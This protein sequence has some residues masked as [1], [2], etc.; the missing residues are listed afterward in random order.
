MKKTFILFILMTSISFLVKA[1]FPVELQNIFQDILDEKISETGAIGISAAVVSENDQWTAA[2]GL[3]ATDSV[4]TTNSIMGMGSITKTITSATILQMMEDGLL[5]LSDPISLYLDTMTNIPSE[6]TISQLLNHTSGIYNYSEHP[7]NILNYYLE[8]LSELVTEEFILENYVDPPIFAPGTQ[9]LYSNSNYLLLALIIETISG[10]AYYLEARE[11]FGFDVNYP[12]FF[13]LPYEKDLTEIAHIFLDTSGIGS[14]P[15]VD[16]V[17]MGY[18]FNSVY[19]GSGAAGAY[20][21]TPSDL[22]QWAYD[23]YSGKILEEAT[24]D[25]LFTMSFP[26][27]DYGL[28]VLFGDLPPCGQFQGHNGEAIYTASAYYNP[29][30][31]IAVSVQCNDGSNQEITDELAVE[32]ACAYYTYSVTTDTEV[33]V[34]NESIEIY[35]NPFSDHFSLNYETNSIGKVQVELYNEIGLKVDEWFLGEQGKGEHLIQLDINIPN[36]IYFLKVQIGEK[37]LSKRMIK[38]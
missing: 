19:S 26:S 11:R 22:A 21:S 18:I 12:S 15:P 30:N 36:G 8:N 38:M 32:L 16:I 2:E 5:S 27:S 31:G 24:M 35:P 10:Q 17:E 4:L 25:S 9:F 33:L 1:Q 23:L 13:L 37:L 6:V 28:G 14:T 20:A 3:H 34:S 29:D 7:D